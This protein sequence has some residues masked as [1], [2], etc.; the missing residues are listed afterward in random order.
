MTLNGLW[1][2]IVSAQ[3]APTYY[4][5]LGSAAAP[6]VHVYPFT[7]AT[8]YGAKFANPSPAYGSSVLSVAM[9][10]RQTEIA[11]IISASPFGTMRAFGPSGFG[12]VV[13][14]PSTLPQ[15]KS[16]GQVTFFQVEALTG[17]RGPSAV[18]MIGTTSSTTAAIDVYLM[19]A[20][21]ASPG[22]GG[23]QTP[24][25]TGTTVLHVDF[26]RDTTNG[27]RVAIQEGGTG[28]SIYAGARV[29]A[30]SGAGFGTAAAAPSSGTLVSSKNQSKSVQWNKAGRNAITFTM[31]GAVGAPQSAYPWTGSAFGTLYTNPTGLTSGSIAYTGVYAAWSPLGD[32]V[33]Y[34]NGLTT[35]IPQ[36]KVHSWTSGSGFGGTALAPAA[37]PSGGLNVAMTTGRPAWAPDQSAVFVASVGSPAGNAP[38]NP[39]HGYAW[40]AGFGTKYAGFTN[41]ADN[42]V[43]NGTIAVA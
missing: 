22:F 23:R 32:Y 35:A 27:H 34:S 14:N 10:Q 15:Q 9:S 43:P 12:T 18:A 8:G 3:G 42:I 40:N 29:W 7:T 20:F 38:Y 1:M 25:T 17:S 13:S 39:V 28:S 21:S 16:I 6:Y 33:A 26:L 31:T 4:I 5:T 2:G 41:T 11:A 19:D 37:E 24:P 36:F 30:W